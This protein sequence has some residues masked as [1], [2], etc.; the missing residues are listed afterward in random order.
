MGKVC[1]ICSTEISRLPLEKAFLQGKT[2]AS[3]SREFNVSED[4]IRHHCSNHLSRQLAKAWSTKELNNSVDMLS[5]LDD[6]ILKAKDIFDR[7]YKKGADVTALKALDSQRNTIELLCKVAAYMH[8]SK[9][10]ELDQMKQQD[11]HERDE[12]IQQDLGVL[13][14]EELKM[15]EAISLKIEKQDSS[16]IIIPDQIDS[17]N[18]KQVV[19]TTRSKFVRTRSK[20]SVP[21]SEDNEDLSG[22]IEAD[23]HVLPEDETIEQYNSRIEAKE[24]GPHGYESG[25]IIPNGERDPYG[26]R[27]A[28]RRQRELEKQPNY[29]A[30]QEFKASLHKG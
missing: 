21:L 20:P 23:E 16:I 24:P 9:L 8:E 6:L 5:I 17:W 27:A 11:T 4:I 25:I 18:K 19:K 29:I 26:N 30:A 13:T 10:M 3:L 7:N 14:I 2:I 1:T 15:L 12:Q 22:V 28:S